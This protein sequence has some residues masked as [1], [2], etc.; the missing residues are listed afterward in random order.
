MAT[1]YIKLLG[2]FQLTVD[3]N[4]IK[5]VNQPRL[6][7]LLAYLLLHR[8]A[9]Q[10]RHHLAFSFWPQLPESQ[11]RNNLRQL[12]HQLRHALPAGGQLLFADVNT[13]QWLAEGPF[14]LDAAEF[15]LA[16]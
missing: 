10:S 5:T 16:A 8:Q 3:A 1:L 11:A 6:Q 12:L 9:P 7:S 15:D 13:V 2:D 4:P 14:H